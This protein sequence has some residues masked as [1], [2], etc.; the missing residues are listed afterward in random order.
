MGQPH[1][2]HEG[3]RHDGKGLV[4]L[5]EVHIVFGPADPFQQFLCRWDR[6]CREQAR[7]L[8][9]ACVPEDARPDRETLRVCGVLGCKHKCCGTIRDGRRICRCNR[10][11][12]AK[13]G[14][15]VR[16]FFWPRGAGLFVRA[17]CRGCLAR[18]HINR[19][20]FVGERAICD[21]GLRACQR[22][23]RIGVLNVSGELKG[24][25]AVFGKG[26]HQTPLVIGIFQPVQKHVIDD[27][28]MAQAGTTPHFGQQVGCPR[29]AFHPACDHGVGMAQGDL[30]K[31][32]H[33]RL[34]AGPA[35]F[36]QRGR[37]HIVPQTRSEP[38]L[39]RGGLPLT[40]RQDAAHQHFV[41]GGEPGPGHRR[42]D[43]NATKVGRGYV[44]QCALET[45]HRGSRRTGNENGF[46]GSGSFED[47]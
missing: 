1:F 6:R 3:K 38:S 9:V 32:D 8:R 45:T 16:D 40:R 20:H 14:F 22:C 10:A 33:C 24:F 44:R 2:V 4:H 18:Y 19:G 42:L 34:H 21:R 25:G 28:G 47:Q 11:P 17:D 46:H 41:N 35:H 39:P 43:C 29:H 36:I 31:G 13:G 12:I 27:L 15:E 26:A 7:C 37:R 5:P 23:Q 30:V